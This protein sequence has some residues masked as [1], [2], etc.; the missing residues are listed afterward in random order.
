M[1]ADPRAE[2][3]VLVVDDEDDIRD[4]VALALADAGYAVDVAPNA[5]AALERAVAE[6][7]A[8]ILL[9]MHNARDGRLG[10]SRPAISCWPDP[11]RHS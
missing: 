6:P 11:A 7:P 10:V 8:A 1:S 2:H 3:R 4:F 5:A 9:D